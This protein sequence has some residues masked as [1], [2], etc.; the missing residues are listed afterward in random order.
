MCILHD[1]HTKDAR[2]AAETSEQR[3]YRFRYGGETNVYNEREGL[4]W[5]GRGR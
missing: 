4:H 3:I 1:M 5:N 2:A